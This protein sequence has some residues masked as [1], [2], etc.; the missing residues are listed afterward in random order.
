[1]AAAAGTVNFGA[2][3]AIT[4]VFRAFDCSRNRIKEA[5]P[6]GATLELG[7]RLEQRL[8]ASCADKGARTLF[9]QQS[10]RAG[11]LRSVLTQHT[12]LLGCQQLSPFSIG[13]LDRKRSAVAMSLV[14][15]LAST[16]LHW[17]NL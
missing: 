2:H 8:S 13:M 7:L 16:R 17:A 1:M 4:R 12:I 5:R 6:A 10:A 15:G 11:R 3:H 9:L 14:H